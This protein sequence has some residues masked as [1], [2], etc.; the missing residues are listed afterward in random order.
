MLLQLL[1]EYGVIVDIGFGYWL[2]ARYLHML[3]R[4]QHLVQYSYIASCRMLYYAR[5]GII[6]NST[7][8]AS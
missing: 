7:E 1:P 2:A 5:Q 6:P 3:P 4:L 8:N